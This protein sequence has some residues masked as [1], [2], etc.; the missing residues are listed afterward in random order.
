[1]TCFRTE[2]GKRLCSGVRTDTRGLVLGLPVML[3]LNVPESTLPPIWNFPDTLIPLTKKLAKSDGVVYDLV[4][5]GLHSQSARH[6]TARYTL[7]NNRDSE[8]FFFNGLENGRY[9]LLEEGATFAKHVA[10]N[11]QNFPAGY[12]VATAIYHL[13]GGSKAQDIFYNIRSELYRKKFKLDVSGLTPAYSSLP[14]CSYLGNLS[15]LPLEART[16][17]KDS[18]TRKL[19]VEYV[20]ALPAP[21]VV[22]LDSNSEDG[23]TL[24]IKVPP[25][26]KSNVRLSTPEKAILDLTVNSPESEEETN[27]RRLPSPAASSSS[28][29]DS[30]WS[31]N[32]RCGV[33]GDGNTLYREDDGTTIQCNDCLD[34]SHIACQRDGRASLLSERKVFICDICMGQVVMLPQ[35]QRKQRE[36]V[37]KYV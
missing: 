20:S 15:K 7:K 10:G 11:S 29:P 35:H 6:F 24:T 12:S 26:V 18:K 22:H 30:V 19:M 17:I 21:P 27:P 8:V 2:E 32:C 25:F 33:K 1:M 14:K 36:S 13:R 16:W 31:L 23:T 3:A 37:R 5:Y 34:W 28:L 9:T 4:G